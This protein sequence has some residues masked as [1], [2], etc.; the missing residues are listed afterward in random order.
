MQSLRP[1]YHVL[2]SFDL[3]EFDIPNEYG[4]SL[5][6]AE[7]LSVSQKGMYH[8][9][10]LLNSLQIQST[11]F[12][13]AFYAQQNEAQVKEIAGRHEIAS[14]NFYHSS[15][16]ETDIAASRKVL[17]AISGQTIAGFRM[18]RLAPVNKKIIA[19]AGYLYDSSLNPTWLPGRYNN[20]NKPRTLFRQDNLWI[21]PS[22]VTPIL[23]IPL[24]WIA[25]KNLPLSFIKRC[26]LQALKKDNYL[27]LYFH[28]W[29][30]TDLSAYKNMPF[31]TRKLSGQQ[32]LD[33]LAAYLEWLT[34][35]A[36]F[37]TIES[38]IRS[39]EDPFIH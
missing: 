28:P 1:P 13:T 24:F 3:E 11:F 20:L 19:D 32:L 6:T 15:F 12:T 31:Y 22:S 23:R 29:E 5:Q 4:A 37:S 25:F 7:Q 9:M 30:F 36:S 2:L 39:Y 27:S 14:H 21:M 26:S 10:P 17:A 38:F 35:L 34:S 16:K 33:K 18:P 8:L